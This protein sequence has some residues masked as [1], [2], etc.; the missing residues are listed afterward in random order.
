MLYPA[1]DYLDSAPHMAVFPGAAI[2]LT[3]WSSNFL[4]INC[5]G[6]GLQDNLDAN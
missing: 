1:Q 4:N 5:I 2:F 6:D 3:V